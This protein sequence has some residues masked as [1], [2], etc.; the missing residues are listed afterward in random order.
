VDGRV[1]EFELEFAVSTIDSDRRVVVL[2]QFGYLR[3]QQDN[4]ICFYMKIRII[5]MAVLAAIVAM[6]AT[7]QRSKKASAVELS[8]NY[9]KQSGA[10]SNQWA[11]WVEN[12]E[13]KVVR[14]LTVTSF[15]SK[16][17]GG[18]RGYTFRPTCTPT[19]VKNAKAEEMSDEQIDAVTGATPSQSGIQTYTWDFKDA[20]GKEVPAGDYKICFEATLYFNS[21]LLYTGTFSTKDKAGEIALTSTLTEEDEA[22]KNM[23]TEVKAALK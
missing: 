14:T 17:R 18:R 16:G 2:K 12:S 6:P 3:T 22:H 7:A 13:G 21:I 19:W 10:G 11:V 8:F 15:T 23:V 20:D 4:Q 5:L 9:Q 1:P